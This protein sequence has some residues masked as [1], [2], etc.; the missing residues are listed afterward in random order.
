MKTLLKN[1]AM[2][3]LPGCDCHGLHLPLLAL[4]RWN[5]QLSHRC[6]YR[7]CCFGRL[8][9]SFAECSIAIQKSMK[10]MPIQPII[11]ISFEEYKG[12]LA[13]PSNKSHMKPAC[14]TYWSF[15]N[16]LLKQ[17]GWWAGEGGLGGGGSAR[18]DSII[19]QFSSK[20]CQT[21]QFYLKFIWKQS[22]MTCHCNRNL[23]FQY[24]PYYSDRHVVPKFSFQFSMYYILRTF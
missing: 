21:L 18:A 6:Y 8:L 1:L 5:I 9:R 15:H 16:F 19:F 24:H 11:P 2:I 7:Q 4:S 10:I 17:T 12:C 23:M 3:F 20:I 22:V 13:L 14:S